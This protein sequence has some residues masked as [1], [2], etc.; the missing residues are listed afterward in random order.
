MQMA[1]NMLGVVSQTL[2]K[3]ADGK[4]RIAA[5]EIL[6]AIPA[7]RNLVREAKTFQLGSIIQT[8]QRHGMQTLDQSLAKLVRSGM[9][10]LDDAQAKASD[11]AEF[12]ALLAEMEPDVTK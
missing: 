8:G 12:K 9:V 6:V 4:G 7:V 2:I 10:R 1:V 11:L 3:R 5:F